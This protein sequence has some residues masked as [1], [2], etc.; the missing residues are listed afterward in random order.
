MDEEYNSHTLSLSPGLPSCLWAPPACHSSGQS[1]EHA[2]RQAR[3]SPRSC[4]CTSLRWPSPCSAACPPPGRGACRAKGITRVG[5]HASTERPER[6]PPSLPATTPALNSLA[7]HPTSAELTLPIGALSR[8]PE[9]HVRVNHEDVLLL[10]GRVGHPVHHRPRL[11]VGGVPVL[12]VVLHG[13]PGGYPGV[14]LRLGTPGQRREG[15]S[16]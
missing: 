16:L 1:R 15:R 3:C 4:K 6:G 2:A 8:P 5:H 11:V 14:H 9:H 12:G 7:Q 13:V 10:G